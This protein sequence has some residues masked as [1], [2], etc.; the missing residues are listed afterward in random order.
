MWTRWGP[1]L[2]ESP[3][4]ASQLRTRTRIEIKQ[5]AEPPPTPISIVISSVSHH[6]VEKGNNAQQTGALGALTEQLA[7]SENRREKSKSRGGGGGGDEVRDYSQ[8][9]EI[10]HPMHKA[11]LFT[12]FL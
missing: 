1:H 3:R 7:P 9:E 5:G 6:M 10:K 2:Q 4:G 11:L 8:C 12:P